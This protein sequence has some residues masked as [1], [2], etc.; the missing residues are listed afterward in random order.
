MS[1]APS[2]LR[3]FAKIC[4]SGFC[5]V[6]PEV[7]Q[8]ECNRLSKGIYE[9]PQVDAVGPNKGFSQSRVTQ[10]NKINIF[11]KVRA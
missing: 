1:V 6:L 2:F 5:S 7:R 10:V 8:T 11:F 9:V 3:V 4:S